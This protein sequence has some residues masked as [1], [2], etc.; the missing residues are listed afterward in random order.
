[1]SDGGNASS[2]QEKNRLGRRGFFYTVLG[3]AIA[4]IS[5]WIAGFY[6]KTGTIQ[7]EEPVSRVA[8]TQVP[9]LEARLIELEKSLLSSTTEAN[10]LTLETR[11]A[12][13][14]KAL[15]SMPAESGLSAMED[16]VTGLEE[17]LQQ[18][19][20][21][22]ELGYLEGEW[23]ERVVFEKSELTVINPAG[24]LLNLVATNGHVGI[25]FYK[26]FGFGNE[27]VTN[28]WH[29][30]YI[31]GVEGYQNLAILRDWRFTAALWDEDG[32]LLLGQLDPHPPANPPPKA[33]LEV[34]GRLD[35]VQAMVQGNEDQS[36][37]ILQ[38][39]DG[40]GLP[41]FRVSG[42]GDAVVGSP[43]ESKGLILYDTADRSAY[44]LKVTNGYLNLTKV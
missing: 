41:Y 39:V 43:E 36:A 19:S 32:K 1:M 8:D 30:G 21:L 31:E 16:R 33:R 12:D 6:P 25:R 11:I 40:E 23:G 13:L 2:G 24:V 35:E 9:T 44:A 10:L 15:V 14:E 34:R 17:T 5:G 22:Q 26:D 4:A 18:A 29:M 7:P 42:T 28:P 37:D 38:I 3:G 27:Q 20:G